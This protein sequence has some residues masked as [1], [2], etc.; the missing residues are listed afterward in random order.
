M[1]VSITARLKTWHPATQTER[2]LKTASCPLSVDVRPLVAFASK[3]LPRLRPQSVRLFYGVP[4]PILDVEFGTDRKGTQWSVTFELPAR[5]VMT[6][7][8]RMM[9]QSNAKA[10]GVATL[11]IDSEDAGGETLPVPTVSAS[12]LAEMTAVSAAIN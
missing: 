7:F 6:L 8:N 1:S 12:A 3:M 10:I 5:Y 2:T 11:A 9:A 4:A